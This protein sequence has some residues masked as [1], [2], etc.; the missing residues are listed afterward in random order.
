MIR[1]EGDLLAHGA[2]VHSSFVKVAGMV[3]GMVAVVDTPPDLPVA[4]RIIPPVSFQEC[5]CR[6]RATSFGAPIPRGFE[7][8]T[9][10]A[11]VA[12]VRARGAAS[13]SR[14]SAQGLARR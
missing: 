3:A 14:R 4:A 6:H 10:W 11:C 7:D 12:L 1:I 2:H 13:R 8:S 9:S 5:K